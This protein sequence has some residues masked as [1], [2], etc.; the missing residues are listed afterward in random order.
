MFKHI[1]G[2][3]T[4]FV[5][6]VGSIW[7]TDSAV[8]QPYSDAQEIVLPSPYSSNID[9]RGNLTNGGA[10]NSGRV[11]INDADGATIDT[12]AFINHSTNAL[13]GSLSGA[14]CLATT[15]AGLVC[16]QSGGLII[17]DAAGGYSNIYSNQT[18]TGLR[19][20][21]Y[22]TTSTSPVYDFTNDQGTPFTAAS[23][24][25]S[26]VD[27]SSAINQSGTAG[28]DWITA[29]ITHTAVGSGT[30]NFMKF[31]V[32]GTTKFRVNSDGILV[33]GGIVEVNETIVADDTT[34][35]VSGASRFVTSANT[36][37]TA[38]TDLDN[39][40]VGQ[41][42]TICGGSNTNSSTIA[43]SG[44]F[45]LS[46]GMTLSLDDCITLH[47]QADN[48]YVELSRVNN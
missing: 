23:G 20:R 1:A 25:Q 26:M 12:S 18:T 16:T 5:F 46:A 45:N 31:S 6:V 38:I 36:G 24:T 48:D 34:P 37:A 41:V 9:F 11:A 33:A 13:Y 32:G 3:L 40:I 22:I 15:G 7:W 8:S 27:F 2:G 35:D 17:N 29:D 47:V 21:G 44:N 43:D 19:L 28:Y 4:A 10:G 14:S 30:K 42:V 39:P